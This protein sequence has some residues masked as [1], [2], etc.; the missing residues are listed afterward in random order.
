MKF[1]ITF[2]FTFL[3]LLVLGYFLYVNQRPL[4]Q[5]FSPSGRRLAPEAEEQSEGRL[6]SLATGEEI[7][8]LALEGGQNHP[9]IVLSKEPAG[10]FLTE[11]VYSAADPVMVDGLLMA[12]TVAQKVRNLTREKEWAEYG[13]D[14]PEVWVEVGLQDSGVKRTQTLYFGHSSPVGDYVYARWVHPDGGAE[15]VKEAEYFMLDSPLKR[16]FV[17]SLYT[18]RQKRIFEKPMDKIKKIQWHT[19]EGNYEWAQEEGLWFW[20]EPLGLLGETA[21]IS[22]IQNLQAGLRDIYVK[23]FLDG[24]MADDPEAQ[25]SPLGPKIS[26][27]DDSGEASTLYLG[28]EWSQRDAYFAAKQGEKALLLLA[29]SNVQSLLKLVQSQAASNSNPTGSR[30]PAATWNR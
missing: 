1:S 25:I 4:L 17:R 19:A 24:R 30:L 5:D 27:V 3:F 13:L 22:F 23:E 28:R 15:A 16:A 14:K 21:Q 26:L 6:L 7:I 12:L 2:V 9:R 29:R 20:T 8:S 18:L 11:P 10:W